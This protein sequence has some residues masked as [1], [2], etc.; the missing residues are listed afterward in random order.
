MRLRTIRSDY[1]RCSDLVSNSLA[2]IDYSFCPASVQEKLLEE[3]SPE[4][5][6]SGL[7]GHIDEQPLQLSSIR[8]QEIVLGVIQQA[9]IRLSRT[10]P[11]QLFTSRIWDAEPTSLAR[12]SAPSLSRTAKPFGWK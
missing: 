6:R 7:L 10:S 8:R 9:V 4:N 3:G 1:D 12:P 5:L 11:S 2:F